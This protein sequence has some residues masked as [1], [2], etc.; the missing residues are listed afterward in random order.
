MLVLY[1]PHTN[2]VEI[3]RVVHESRNVRAPATQGSGLGESRAKTE[4]KDGEKNPSLQ[5]L[6]RMA[7]LKDGFCKSLFTTSPAIR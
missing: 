5:R 2:G 4:G 6:E 7:A 1:R 3:L